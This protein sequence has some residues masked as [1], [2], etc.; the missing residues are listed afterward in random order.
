MSSV[1]VA[2]VSLTVLLITAGCL[3]AVPSNTPDTDKAVQLEN[4]WNR[5]VEVDLRVVRGTTDETVYGK[6]HTLDPGA[7]R[8]VYDLSDANPDGVESFRIVAS[9]LNATEH[10]TISTN[11]CHGDAYVRIDADG[12]LAVFHSI[13]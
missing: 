2:L 7:E 12:G 3:G 5:S 13:C 10:T 1:R 11:A 6:T 4:D 9:A 8:E